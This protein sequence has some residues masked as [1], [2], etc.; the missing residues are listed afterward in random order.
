MSLSNDTF[1]LSHGQTKIGGDFGSW[2]SS[3]VGRLQH[4]GDWWAERRIRNREMQ[5]LYSFSDREL[6][7]VGL[8]RSDLLAIDKGTYRKE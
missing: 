4:L 1:S 7:D 2:L 5:E 3:I 8:S 6:W